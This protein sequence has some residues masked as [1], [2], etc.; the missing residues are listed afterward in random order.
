MDAYGVSKASADA[1]DAGGVLVN[2]YPINAQNYYSVTGGGTS[3]VGSKYVYSATNVRLSELKLS[4]DVP[5]N[6]WVGW[7]NNVNV[8]LIGR[9]LFMLYNK[10]PFDPEITA[11]TGTFYQGIDYFMMPST[12]NLGFAVKLSF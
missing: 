10:A 8:S 2:G 6:K 1:R 9:N 4:Y 12:R 11:N 5:V 7:V 3:G